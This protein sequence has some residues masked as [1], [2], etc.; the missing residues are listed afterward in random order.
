MTEFYKESDLII[1]HALN[2]SGH[3]ILLAKLR[4]SGRVVYFKL[5]KHNK[6]HLSLFEVSLSELQRLFIMPNLTPK[7]SL[8]KKNGHIIGLLSTAFCYSAAEKEGFTNPFCSIQYEHSNLTFDSDYSRTA[9]DIPIYFLNQFPPGFFAQLYK[10]A[11][12]KNE[13]VF[14]MDPLASVLCSSYSLEED[15]LHKGNLGFYIVERQGIKTVVFFKIDHDLSMSDSIMSH[16]ESRVVNWRHGENAF[17]ISTR[18]LVHFPKLEDSKNHYWPTSKRYVVNPSDSKVYNN[19]DDIIAFCELA[20]NEEF[21][22]AKW[23]AWYKHVLIQSALIESRLGQVLDREDALERAQI[24]LMT[25]ASIARVSRLKAVLFSISSFREYLTQLT[26]FERKTLI[27]EILHEVKE[28]ERDIIG[29]E[30]LEQ[31]NQY[32]DL[33]QSEFKNDDTPLHA[34]I[35]LGDYR[36]DQTWTYFKEFANAVNSEG[37]KPIDLALHAARMA[38]ANKGKHERDPRKNPFF[39]INDLLNHGVDKTTTYRQFKR[40][41]PQ[42]NL[43]SYRFPTDYL[44]RAS[45]AKDAEE[46]IKVFQS[47]GEDHCFSLKMQKEISVFCMRAFLAKREPD[48]QLRMDLEKLKIAL[49]GTKTQPPRPELQFIRQLRST[50]WIVRFIRGLLGGTSTKIELNQIIDDARKTIPSNLT[51]CSCFFSGR[52]RESFYLSSPKIIP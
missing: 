44:N 31:M 11:Q 5:N 21:K 30:L 22:K 18:D 46:L 36:Y 9:E 52:E 35:R 1:D 29:Q 28:A 42:A 8:V 13:L 16:Y 7:Y 50:L 19:T 20:N 25:Q 38:L 10:M 24:A 34:A 15:D 32:S 51:C 23:R 3:T 47:L 39:I 43:G 6:A 45:K 37:E 48:E 2:G 27:D 14:D 41:Y 40:D 26:Q 4:S 12:E 33:C 17:K 49:N